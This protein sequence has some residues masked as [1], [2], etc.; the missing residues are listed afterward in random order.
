MADEFASLGVNVPAEVVEIEE[1]TFEVWEENVDSLNAFFAVET[2][3]RVLAIAGLGGGAVIRTG[4][5]YAA[6]DTVL[7]RRRLGNGVFEDILVMEQAT[8]SAW[9]EAS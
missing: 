9:N 2:Q 5:D 4:L 6:V 7:R 8:L 1:P 3:W